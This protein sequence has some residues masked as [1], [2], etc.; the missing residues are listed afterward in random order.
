VNY[1]NFRSSTETLISTIMAESYKLIL[2][3]ATDQL[4]HFGVYQKN[5]SSPGL[6]SVAWHVCGVPPNQ[7]AQVNWTM[8]Y[9][10]CIADFF[11]DQHKFEG[12]H[13]D[14]IGKSGL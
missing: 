1:Y 10:L 2:K 11:Q 7:S 14:G 13:A 4:W 3:K 5:P 9:G 8:S 6:T 12:D